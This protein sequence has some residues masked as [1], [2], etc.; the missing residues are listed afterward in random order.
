MEN[1]TV[2]ERV[3]REQKEKKAKN[4]KIGLIVLGVLLVIGFIG[5][6]FDKGGKKINEDKAVDTTVSAPF[7]FNK[8]SV[9]ALMKKDNLFTLSKLELGKDS[10]LHIW[11]K[12]Y[13]AGENAPFY[14]DTAYHLTD[15]GL[16]KEIELYKGKKKIS[17]YGL[18]TEANNKEFKEHILSNGHC[19]AVD[20]AIKEKLNDANSYEWVNGKWYV[21]GD[22]IYEV[23]CEFT[24]KNAFN[25][26]IKNQAVAKVFKDGT[27]LSVKIG[28]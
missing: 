18:I 28:E 2:V 23:D 3:I 6:R 11:L 5:S 7:R 12:D 22:G 26:T 9:F 8:D 25:A 1:E 4:R 27:V 21:E 14:Y 24:A 20:D 19:Y 13:D 10:I 17:S 16:I 15:G